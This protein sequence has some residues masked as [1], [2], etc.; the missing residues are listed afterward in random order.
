MQQHLSSENGGEERSLFSIMKIMHQNGKKVGLIYR[1]SG[2]YQRELQQMG[3]DCVQADISEFSVNGSMSFLGSVIKVSKHLRNYAKRIHVNSYKDITWS[4][5]LAKKLSI[6]IS[7]HLR[8][9]A[10]EYLSRQ[11]R[12]GIGKTDLLI[13][14]TNFVKLDWEKYIAKPIHVVWNGI[15]RVKS[16]EITKSEPRFAMAFLARIVPEK[17]LQVIVEAMPKCKTQF[18][19]RVIGSDKQ[20]QERGESDFFVKL[21]QR[22][23]ELGLQNNVEFLGHQH[24]PLEILQT[25]D[26]LIVPSFHDS[27][28]RTLMEAMML[29]IPVL[30]SKCGGT[31]EL[32]SMLPQLDQ[33]SFNEGG[34]TDLAQK[35]DFFYSNF[36]SFVGTGKWKEFAHHHFDISR[37]VVS[38]QEILG[39]Q[40]YD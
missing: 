4:A 3:V 6:P 11:Y 30:A 36:E 27:F 33:L 25:C 26:A 8:L 37:T 40:S 29:D 32:T 22:V 17:G 1:K 19:L 14:N 10:P 38:M 18:T 39:L 20:A 15:P 31:S 24:N 16:S 5:A 21:K 7:L 34:E 12:W 35:I 28:G 23:S 13:A 2:D 9:N